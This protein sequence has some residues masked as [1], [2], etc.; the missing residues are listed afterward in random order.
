MSEAKEMVCFLDCSL[1]YRNESFFL[2]R[3]SH[4]TLKNIL[5][6]L[7]YYCEYGPKGL[8]FS[9]RCSCISFILGDFYKKNKIEGQNDSFL[10]LE[11]VFNHEFFSSSMCMEANTNQSHSFCYLV[12]YSRF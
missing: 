11:R 8:L 9:D 2:R 7:Q 1:S 4:K 10:D 3:R 5:F 6:Y 12:I